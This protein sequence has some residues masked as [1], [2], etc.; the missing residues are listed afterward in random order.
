MQYYYMAGDG[1]GWSSLEVKKILPT[2]GS[3]FFPRTPLGDLQHYWEKQ[4][5]F[6]DRF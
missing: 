3:K 6:E 4:L 1:V 2:P 5:P